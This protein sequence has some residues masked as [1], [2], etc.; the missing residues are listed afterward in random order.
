MPMLRR[1]LIVLILL[2]SLGG[3]IATHWLTGR[4]Q[5][6][7]TI[8]AIIPD[9]QG[10]V[11]PAAQT[12][13]DILT[14]SVRSLVDS[15]CH[16]DVISPPDQI[17]RALEDP[18]REAFLRAAIERRG[19]VLSPR[20]QQTL[21][22]VAKTRGMFLDHLR[23]QPQYDTLI[24]AVRRIHGPLVDLLRRP[25]TS[26]ILPVRLRQE[27]SL[28]SPADHDPIYPDARAADL[29]DAWFR[30][31]EAYDLRYHRDLVERAIVTAAIYRE[32]AIASVETDSL[33]QAAFPPV[34]HG[35]YWIAGH[36]SPDI[37]VLNRVHR[38]LIARR[39]GTSSPSPGPIFV[40][41][42]PITITARH[43]VLE[44][45]EDNTTPFVTGSFP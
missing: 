8:R 3:L 4:P 35:R 32:A 39:T 11:M 9:A 17:V 13:F 33:G 26:S 5:A 38:H 21:S 12:R 22:E 18:E 15:I 19:F 16:I 29:Y 7:M 27:V 14:C 28:F 2:I 37:H 40:W 25:R 36:Y 44:L 10:L 20:A 24:D 1:F 34:R 6:V 30:A 43:P 23:W 31:V 42:F 41:D 45:S